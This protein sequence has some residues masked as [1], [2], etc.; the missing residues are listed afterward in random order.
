[1]RRAGGAARAAA[2][3]RALGT[4]RGRAAPP[5][6]RRRRVARPPRPR[7]AAGDRRRGAAR[8]R[9]HALRPRPGGARR[10]HRRALAPRVGRAAGPGGG[11]PRGRAGPRG[12]GEWYAGLLAVAGHLALAAPEIFDPLDAALRTWSPD[13]FRRALPDLRRA[14][15]SLL[16][17]ERRALLAHLQPGS[18]AG[19]PGGGGWSAGADLAVPEHALTALVAREDALW[20]LVEEHTGPLRAG[21][22][23]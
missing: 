16:P 6:R 19:G 17:R 3:G 5:R 9:E 10:P 15:S 12:D 20:A 13:D 8:P 7:A 23:R 21:T 11:R 18:G 1:M 4:P 14:A 2:P 22:A